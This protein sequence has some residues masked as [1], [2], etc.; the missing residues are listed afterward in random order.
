MREVGT[1]CTRGIQYCSIATRAT[2]RKDR[3]LQL[4]QRAAS[5]S[6]YA[7]DQT[8]PLPV[9]RRSTHAV[10]PTGGRG[11]IGGRSTRCVMSRRKGAHPGRSRLQ[12]GLGLIRLRLGEVG[13][14]VTKKHRCPNSVCAQ[15]VSWRMATMG[16][17]SIDYSFPPAGYR[18]QG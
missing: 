5:A 7:G 11:Q 6:T 12:E 2:T 15:V 4:E 1:A 16:G 10:F 17:L 9:S 18:D 3:N 8:K 14:H 13:F